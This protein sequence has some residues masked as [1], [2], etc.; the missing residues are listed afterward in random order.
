MF[1]SY[2]PLLDLPVLHLSTTDSGKKG[3]PTPLLTYPRGWCTIT[4]NWA[5]DCIE[6]AP[7]EVKRGAAARNVL[8]KISS[9]PLPKSVFVF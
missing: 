2:L 9:R 6:E 8:K 3:C 7:V 4:Y 5:R 1:D